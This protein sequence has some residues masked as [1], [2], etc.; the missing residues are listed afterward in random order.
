MTKNGSRHMKE[1]TLS[2][3]LMKLGI[4]VCF[5]TLAFY[6]IRLREKGLLCLLKIYFEFF[7]P[8]LPDSRKFKLGK[9]FE[10]SRFFDI[11]KVSARESLYA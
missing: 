8:N 9:I 4:E 5:V 1:E 6:G 7:F 10:I 2:I 3:Y 11:A